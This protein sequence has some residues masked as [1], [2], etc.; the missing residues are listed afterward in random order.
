MFIFSLLLFVTLLLDFF[1]YYSSEMYLKI[2][3]FESMYRPPLSLSYLMHC[4][5]YL[6]FVTNLE[7]LSLW[8]YF[9]SC[10]YY[11]SADTGTP[12]TCLLG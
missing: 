7:F 10:V 12:E 5:I 6:T 4:F 3:Y 1:Y 9:Q 2:K 11:T 8:Q